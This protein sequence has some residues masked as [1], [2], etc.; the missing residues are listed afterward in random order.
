M[1]VLRANQRILENTLQALTLRGH[2]CIE[3]QKSRIISEFPESK[4]VRLR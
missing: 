4:A 3:A 2:G 1:V